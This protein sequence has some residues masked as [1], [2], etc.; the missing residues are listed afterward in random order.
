MKEKGNP[1]SDIILYS[2][3]EGNVKV[4]VIYSGETFWLTQKRLAELFGVTVP[5]IRL[6]T[7]QAGKHLKNIP[8]CSQ[9]GLKPVSYRR[10]QL[11]PKWK[12]L[13]GKSGQ[14]NFSYPEF[15]EYCCISN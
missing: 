13:P 5:A 8:A 10:I 7:G 11:F 6:P 12:Q 1:S 4:E 14:F 3:P 9:T 15:P 2:S